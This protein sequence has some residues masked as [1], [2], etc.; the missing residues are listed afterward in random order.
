MIRKVKTRNY[1]EWKSLRKQYIGGS[2]S[3]AVLGMNSYKSRYTLW[4]EKTGRIPE[5]AGNLATD[6]G[7]YFED[8]IAKRFEQ[9]TGKKVRKEM[10]SIFN[11]KYPWAI[12]NVDRVIVGEDA[13]LE[14]KFTDSLNLK[15]YKNGEFP[16]RFYVQCVHYLAITG[17]KKAYLAVLIGNKEFKVFEIY[18]DEAEIDALMA[19][20][21]AFMELI[22]T[23]TAPDTDGTNSTTETIKT[24]YADSNEDSVN[25][26]AYEDALNQYMAVQTQIKELE[27]IKDEMANK[28]KVFMGEAGKGETDR[29]K[30]S[31]TSSERNTFDSKTF[32]SDH[33]NLDL[34]KYYKKTTVRTFKVNK[35]AN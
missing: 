32:A 33:P 18:R 13:I 20:E 34:T 6:V 2:D 7:T 26:F 3:A 35:K 9:E 1:E 31:W 11:D 12:A 29:F 23:D 21:K 27:A 15:R 10:H 4:A 24:I 8:F 25:L 17:K 5:F 22:K 14:C 19:E 28:V 16:D 30:V